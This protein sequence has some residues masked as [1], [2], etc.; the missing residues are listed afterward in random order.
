MCDGFRLHN[1]RRWSGVVDAALH[2]EGNSGF[3]RGFRAIIAGHR[4]IVPAWRTMTMMTR[5]FGLRRHAGLHGNTSRHARAMDE[6]Q[7]DQ[8]RGQNF[9]GIHCSAFAISVKSSR[10]VIGTRK[11]RNAIRKAAY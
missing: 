8:N 3:E 2:H 5:R 7:A 1:N 9:H 11:R 10:K 4:G 6:E